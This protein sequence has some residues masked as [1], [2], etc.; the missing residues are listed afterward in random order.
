MGDELDLD[1]NFTPASLS[2]PGITDTNG[3]CDAVLFTHNHKDHIGQLKNLRD[4]VPLYM[5]SLAKDIFLVT[6]TEDDALKLRVKQA[7]IFTPG[8]RFQIGDIFV[9]PFTVDHSAC[10]S[11]MFLIDADGKKILYTGD[12]RL[13]GFRGKAM[14]KILDKLVGKVDVLIIEGTTLSRPNT[15]LVTEKELQKKVKGYL[16]QYQYVFVL[17]ASTNLDRICALSKAVPSGKYFI[18]DE[19]QSKLLDLM[20]QHWGNY[21]SL[22]QNIKKTVYGEN[23]L[24]CFRE[25][26]FLMMVR[27]NRE[28]RKIIRQFAPE[29]SLILY[30]MWDGYRTN[31]GSSIPDF[32]DLTGCW[33]PL[34]TSGHA[35]QKAIKM[36]IEKVDPDI[37]IPI[38]TDNPDM[39]QSVCPQ[40]KVL[41]LRDGEIVNV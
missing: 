13:H 17:C 22:Y 35:S 15:E 39:L 8:K 38:H 26:G 9:T 20:Q 23:L 2:I 14:L 21:S 4:G 10:D 41:I 12:F 19:Y 6:P 7:R 18:C 33:K 37:V 24:Q 25:K 34:H 5:G 32:L 11:Y 29:K 3:N 16:E 1:E 36:V 30:S 31:G 27:N 28:F 40:K